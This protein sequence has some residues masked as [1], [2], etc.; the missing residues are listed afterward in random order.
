MFELIF[1]GSLFVALLAGNEEVICELPNNCLFKIP[2][3]E[4]LSRWITLT[5]DDNEL[6]AFRIW[7]L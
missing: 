6:C 3:S 2:S 4:G 5:L 1:K 7:A